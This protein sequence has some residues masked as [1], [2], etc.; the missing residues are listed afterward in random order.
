MRSCSEGPGTQSS[1]G[2]SEQDDQS[3]VAVEYDEEVEPPKNLGAMAHNTPL[4]DVDQLPS[5][6]RQNIENHLRQKIVAQKFTESYPTSNA[7][8]PITDSSP[9]IPPSGPYDSNSD[10]N[11]YFPFSDRMNWEIA[12]WAKL[13]GPGSTAISELLSIDKVCYGIAEYSFGTLI[14]MFL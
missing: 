6:G 2:S 14:L 7:G 11:P 3:D 1:D 9:H 13:R 8:A 5:I 4:I 12:C 10:N